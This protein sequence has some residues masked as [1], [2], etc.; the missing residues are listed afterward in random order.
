MYIIPT[1]MKCA[2][3]TIIEQLQK[4]IYGLQ[5]GNG[6]SSEQ[7]LKIGLGEIESA[8]PDKVF[9]TGVVHELISYSSEEAT[10]TSGFVSVVLSKLM[11]QGGYCLWIS[12]IPRRSV[13]P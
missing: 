12:T 1:P 4:Q 8:F 6:R 13:F 2:D 11:Q 10:C 5:K 3:R 9:P 7:P